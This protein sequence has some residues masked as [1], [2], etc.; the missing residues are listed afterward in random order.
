MYFQQ[1]MEAMEGDNFDYENELGPVPVSE[2]QKQV[3]VAK[4]V[5]RAFEHVRHS[6][7]AEEVAGEVIGLCLKKKRKITVKYYIKLSENSRFDF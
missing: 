7:A 6:Q 3:D 1:K 5:D 4:I 2:L